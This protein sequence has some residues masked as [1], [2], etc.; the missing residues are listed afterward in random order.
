MVLNGQHNLYQQFAVQA[1]RLGDKPALIDEQQNTLTFRQ[2]DEQSGRIANALVKLGLT[3]G[4][5]VTVQVQKS[6]MA[7]CLYLA[8]LRVGGVFHPLNTGYQS[9]ELAFFI[10]NAQPSIVVSDSAALTLFQSLPGAPDEANILSLNADGSGSLTDLANTQSDTF[11]T[12]QRT[13][14]DPAA[15]LYSS[16]TTG[17]P[18]GIDLCH[19]NLVSNAAT[20]T[21]HWEF[22][23]SDVL[24]H[25]LPIFH[26]H[27]LFVAIGCALM[28]GACMRWLPTFDTQTV[29]NTLPQCSVMMGVPTYYTRLLASAAFTREVGAERRLFISG[30]APLLAETF[31]DFEERT[32]HRIVERYG[33][34]ETMINTSSPLH[35]ERRAGTVGLPLADIEVRVVDDHGHAVGPGKTGQIEVRG[36]NVFSGYWRAPEKTQQDFTQDK[37]FRTGDNGMWDED[38]YLSIVGRAK[39]MVITGGLNVYPREVELLLDQ[40]PG[41][42]ESAVIGLAH[43]D[44]GEAVVAVVVPDGDQCV[45]ETLIRA[46]LKSQ[47]AGFKVPKR[48]IS[49]DQL[50]RNTMGKVQ[51]NQLRK[52]FSGLFA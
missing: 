20:L 49:I 14:S 50:P 15:L 16:G 36:P 7:L 8:C 35:G 32:G 21:E 24:L 44:F 23:E 39:D 4:D 34:T 37:F 52:Q 31:Q 26:V 27:G 9:S 6:P 51:K 48:V 11:D 22:S 42:M 3:P 18:K 12:V 28:S 46:E 41:V 5:R 2:L 45:D 30:S 17:T 40:L 13:A 10:D 19:G 29:I 33:L 38:G 43:A 1:E 47:I 25:A